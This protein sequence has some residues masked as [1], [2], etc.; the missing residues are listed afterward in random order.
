M[1]Q[2]TIEEEE[3][4]VSEK[5]NIPIFVVVYNLFVLVINTYILITWP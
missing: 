3:M 4:E 5:E 2:S 1:D